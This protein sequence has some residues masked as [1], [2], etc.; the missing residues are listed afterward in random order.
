MLT[1]EIIDKIVDLAA[2]QIDAALDCNKSNSSDI[3]YISAF[4]NNL[5]Q[6]LEEKGISTEAV[7]YES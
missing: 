7:Y 4:R 5:E 1:E 3:K 2:E 6:L